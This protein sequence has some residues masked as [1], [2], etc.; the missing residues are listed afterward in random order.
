MRTWFRHFQRAKDTEDRK[1]Y[2]D[3]DDVRENDELEVSRRK[4]VQVFDGHRAA[5]V[6]SV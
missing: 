3:T 6:D 5:V 4:T 1:K 2:D